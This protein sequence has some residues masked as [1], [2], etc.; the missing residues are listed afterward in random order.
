[1]ARKMLFKT[2]AAGVKAVATGREIEFNSEYNRDE[3]GFIATWRENYS[4]ELG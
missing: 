2:V 3:W 4:E 1:M